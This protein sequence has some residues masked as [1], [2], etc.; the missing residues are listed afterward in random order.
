MRNFRNRFKVLAND[1][2]TDIKAAVETHLNVIRRTLDIVRNENAAS[3]AE[4]DLEFRNCV[5]A[6]IGIVKDHIRQIQAAAG[7]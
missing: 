1:L 6:K 2:Q 3:E 4:Q 5:E 7:L